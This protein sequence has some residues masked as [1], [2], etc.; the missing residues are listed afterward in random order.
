MT[1][2]CGAYSKGF[3][4]AFSRSRRAAPCAAAVVLLAGAVTADAGQDESGRALYQAACAN[5]HGSDGR[6][7]DPALVVFT[8]PLPDFS[9]CAFATREPDADWLAVMH[10]GGPVRAF[11]RMMPA[12]D[13]ALSTAQLERILAH[14]RS[15]CADTDWPRGELNLPRPLVTEKAFPEDE[16]VLSTT[17][18][19]EGDADVASR[20][21]YER[22]VGARNQI[23]VVV[24]FGWSSRPGAAG[25]E[26]LGGIGD[27]AL[28]FKRAVY[29][30]LQQGRILSVGGEVV[31]STG[32]ESKGLGTGTSIVEPFAA[33]A[34]ILPRDSF[35]QVQAGVELPVDRERASR[36]AFWRAAVGRSIS[37][38][39]WGRTWSPMVEILGARGLAAGGP[40]RWDVLPQ[41][42]VTL[43]TRQ[44]VMVNVG[45]RIPVTQAAA[46]PTQVL[47]Y[48]LWDWFDGPLFEGW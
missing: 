32:D 10:E 45:L 16:A 14:V 11:S 41:V 19:A 22:R 34:Q 29:H 7:A 37:E 38:G 35:I 30:S 42:Q 5:C 46:R 4:G 40:A 6:G 12:F 33:F 36:E 3:R 27:V 17:A 21:V 9:N 43:S 47:F 18:A 31:L 39:R 1:K 24:P 13:R 44:H 26:W 48:F 2:R 20:L 25:R 8:E 15:F 23:E 28:G